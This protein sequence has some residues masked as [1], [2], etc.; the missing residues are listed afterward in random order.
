MSNSFDGYCKKVPIAARSG[1]SGLSLAIIAPKTRQAPS[2][3]F[4]RIQWSTYIPKPEKMQP[5]FSSPANE[6]NHRLT[7]SNRYRIID[8]KSA[9]YFEPQASDSFD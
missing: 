1:L 5:E 7:I 2:E 4:I 9:T 6:Q 8:T 3:T